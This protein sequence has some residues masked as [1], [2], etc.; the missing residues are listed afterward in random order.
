MNKAIIE[1][2]FKLEK[3]VPNTAADIDQRNYKVFLSNLDIDRALRM[4]KS[5]LKLSSQAVEAVANGQ[6]ADF[7]SITDKM[8]PLMCYIA[9]N[10]VKLSSF[11]DIDNPTTS[12]IVKREPNIKES[13]QALLKNIKTIQSVNKAAGSMPFNSAF[14]ASK[15]LT[16]AFIDF[17]IDLAWDYE[18]DPVILINLDDLRLIDYLV[19]R[20]QKRFILAGGEIDT[21]NCESVISSNAE[22]FKFPDYQP[23]KKQGGIPVFSGRPMHRF[24]IFDMGEKKISQ[25]EIEEIILGVH[26]SRN[27]QWGKFN[28]I[29]RA[30]TTRIINNLANMAIYEQTSAFHNTLEGHAAIIV[31]RLAN[32]LR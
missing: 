8:R 4:Y 14:L 19:A 18:H 24:T 27:D 10:N 22:L 28:T 2:D 1:E 13:V 29:N 9:D 31:S 6:H 11:F 12:E 26:N 30:D 20:G 15:E 3:S 23:L 17:K 21:K 25:N 7:S 5:L 16:N 32:A